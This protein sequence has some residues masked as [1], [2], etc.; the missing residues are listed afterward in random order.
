MFETKAR[1]LPEWFYDY[2][3]EVF[4]GPSH[5]PKSDVNHRGG[6]GRKESSQRN[7]ND[8]HHHDHFRSF[9]ATIFSSAGSATTNLTGRRGPVSH[10]G[11]AD[12]AIRV[13]VT[14]DGNLRGADK[15]CFLQSRDRL[16]GL[17]DWWKTGD[18][19]EKSLK[20]TQLQVAQ[21]FP[22]CVARQ[23]VVHRLVY[24][25]SPLEAGVDAVCQWCAILFRTSVATA[26][27]VVSKTNFEPGIGT[28]AAKVVADCI[29]SSRVKEIGLAL[30]KKESD[31]VEGEQSTDF[32]L[33]Y[34][35]LSE[36]E[37]KKLQRKLSRVIITF[38]ELLHVLIARNR[39]LLLN[40]IKKRK[41][42]NEIVGNIIAGGGSS[43]RGFSRAASTGLRTDATIHKNPSSHK[44]S[45]TDGNQSDTGIRSETRSTHNHMPSDDQ[46]SYQSA[47][48]AAGVRTDSAIAV[49]SELQRSFIKLV[50]DL[51]P[52][53]HGILQ[54]ETPRWLKQCTVE[55]YFSQGIYQQTKVVISE[56]LCFI[57]VTDAGRSDSNHSRQRSDSHLSQSD[58]GYDSPRG[59]IGGASQSSAISRGSDN[60]GM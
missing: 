53:L 8:P 58:N 27:M 30:L 7:G 31:L 3:D 39:D 1:G 42:S 51:H 43:V 26:G 45:S 17:K 21:S 13:S 35:R 22:A 44:R 34:G 19:A 52:R 33:D 50:K 46:Q 47:F 28:D 36:E 16:K 4:S 41:E 29:H 57:S 14:N 23:A 10:L 55:N 9:S 6:R 48:T 20:V 60:Y 15:F 24:A 25:Q 56:E 5:R 2:V 12:R 18:F 49:Q 11:A 32:S 37:V 54:S 38:V 40:I 59:S